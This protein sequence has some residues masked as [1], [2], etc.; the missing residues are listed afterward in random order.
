MSPESALDG[1]GLLVAAALFAYLLGSIPFGLMLT[2]LGGARRHPHDRLGQYR[3]HQRA[4]HRP[5]WPR[6]R[7]AAA[8]RAEGLL[9][10]VLCAVLLPLLLPEVAAVAAVCAVIGHCFPVWLRFRGG[11]GVA[12]A[13]GV[14]LALDWRVGP[15]CCL[16]WLLVARLT[17]ISS[18]GALAAMAALGPL[19]LA[20]DGGRAGVADPLGRVCRRRS[21]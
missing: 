16:V 15:G 9:A 7:N 5:A 3:R 11:K 18:A 17:R 12:T 1:I 10:V 21:A 14:A 6:R 8:R 4:A 13:L 20:F 19:L 2:R